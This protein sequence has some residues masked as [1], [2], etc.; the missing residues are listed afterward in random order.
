MHR[1]EFAKKIKELIKGKRM[2][3]RSTQEFNE[4]LAKTL[5]REGRLCS[6]NRKVKCDECILNINSEELF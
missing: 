6:L 4:F 3:F 1:E 5:C 2:T